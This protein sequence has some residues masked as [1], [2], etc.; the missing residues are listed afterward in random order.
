VQTML[1][2]FALMVSTVASA[3]PPTTEQK[4]KDLQARVFQLEYQNIGLKEKLEYLESRVYDLESKL[5]QVDK[6]D[7]RLN[8]L[9]MKETFSPRN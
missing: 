1:V 4:V 5:K 6:L 7:H 8:D 2:M 3:E 9:E